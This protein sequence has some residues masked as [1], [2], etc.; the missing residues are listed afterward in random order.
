MGSNM[1]SQQMGAARERACHG[2]VTRR[3][4]EEREHRTGMRWPVVSKGTLGNAAQTL[5]DEG[6]KEAR[7]G[8]STAWV[9]LGMY[10]SPAS[11]RCHRAHATCRGR[12]RLAP[13]AKECSSQQLGLSWST[14]AQ[15]RCLSL[16]P[17]WAPW[18]L[19][20]ALA[21]C[22]LASSPAFSRATVQRR[23]DGAGGSPAWCSFLPAH[24]TGL[25]ETSARLGPRRLAGGGG[26]GRR[27]GGGGTTG[28]KRKA[29]AVHDAALGVR[30]LV[31]LPS[32]QI[33]TGSGGRSPSDSK[34]ARRRLVVPTPSNLSIPGLQQV[35]P[36]SGGTSRRWCTG[37]DARKGD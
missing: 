17:R 3:T 24:G 30:V 37:D 12:L 14:A 18:S 7:A 10:V 25:R 2:R 15:S 5:G 11:A 33:A 36:S 8:G 19:D 9:G 16:R 21:L 23:A 34:Q 13:R 1:P 32:P 6:R 4:G 31:R 29:A 20:P 35:T 26:R 27:R 28:H 22:L